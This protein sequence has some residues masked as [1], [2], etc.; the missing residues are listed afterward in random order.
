MLRNIIFDLGGLFIDVYMDRTQQQLEQLSGCKLDAMLAQLK[1][2]NVFDAYEKGEI[3]SI[4]F[5]LKLQAALPVELSVAQ[6][7]TA[8][9][10]VLGDF[11]RERLEGIQPLRSK[12]KIFLLSNTN[13]LHVAGFEEIL[14]KKYGFR[15]LAP[16]FDKV[17][18]SQHMGLR[19]PDAAIYHQVLLENKLEASE[20]LFIDDS[21]ANLMGA[22]KM[23]LH[24]A[25]HAPNWDIVLTLQEFGLFD[26]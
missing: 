18:F 23:G 20:T 21:P 24:T 22:K 6:I 5:L 26:D 9:N 11:H 14:E 15:S 7:T 10:A 3:S 4:V 1:A 12:Y 25:H 13:E 16:F 2:E 17:Y 19:K 8:W